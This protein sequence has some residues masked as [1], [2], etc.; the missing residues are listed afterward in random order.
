M[1]FV[2]G[3]SWRHADFVMHVMRHLADF[4]TCGT[5]HPA[6]LTGISFVITIVVRV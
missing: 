4:G 2:A 6:D 3:V 5:W 1:Q